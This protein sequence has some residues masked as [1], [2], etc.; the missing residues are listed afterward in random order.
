MT[1]EK[2]VKE[3]KAKEDKTPD[4]KRV[5]ITNDWTSSTILFAE[6]VEGSSLTTPRVTAPLNTWRR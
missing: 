5:I 2:E 1:D 3:D 6:A 4:D